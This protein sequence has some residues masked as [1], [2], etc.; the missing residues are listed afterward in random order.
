MNHI[1]RILEFS[2]YTAHKKN[3]LQNF[4]Y[5]P[6]DSYKAYK[7][8]SGYELLSEFPGKQVWKNREN[9]LVVIFVCSLDWHLLFFFY[10]ARNP[11]LGQRLKKKQGLCSGLFSLRLRIGLIMEVGEGWTP[12]LLSKTGERWGAGQ[13]GQYSWE[14]RGQ[15]WDEASARGEAKSL[16]PF[17][18]EEKQRAP[19]LSCYSCLR[20]AKAAVESWLRR[21]DG[22]QAVKSTLIKE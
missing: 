2:D 10:I 1:S 8:V 18:P 9:F 7:G 11:L 16:P 15:R 4:T 14:A 17:P 20:E 3:R 6:I 19:P 12:V 22:D 5:F 21:V 13:G